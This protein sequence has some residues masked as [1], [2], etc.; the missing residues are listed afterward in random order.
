MGELLHHALGQPRP[1]RPCHRPL[2]HQ[3]CR[4]PPHRRHRP[5]PTRPR[6]PPVR[7]RARPGDPVSPAQSNAGRLGSLIVVSPDARTTAPRAAKLLDDI[8]FEVE[9]HPA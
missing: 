1:P 9:P 4:R 8:H 2:P 3:P 6:T 5:A 7:I